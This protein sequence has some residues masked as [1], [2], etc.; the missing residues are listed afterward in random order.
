MPTSLFLLA[1]LAV[2]C[3]VGGAGWAIRRRVQPGRGVAARSTVPRRMFAAPGGEGDIL[4]VAHGNPQDREVLHRLYAIAFAD[5]AF[6]QGA[7]VAGS[8]HAEVVARAVSLLGR[9]ES[10]PRYTPRRPQVLPQLM[11]TV[12]DPDASG[13]AMAAIIGQDPVLAGN[14]LRIASSPLYRAQARPVEDIAHAVAMVGT[15]GIRQLIATALMQPVM[16]TGGAGV[17]GRF[18]DLVW[19]HTLLSAVAAADHAAQEGGDAFAAQLL[20][21][22]QGL[23]SVIVVRIVRDQ[24]AKRPGLVPDAGV[25]AAVLDAWAVPTAQKIAE[26]WELPDRIGQALADQPSGGALDRLGRSLRFGRQAGALAL[27]CSHGRMQDAEA[28]AA[29]TRLDDRSDVTATIWK[30]LRRGG[31][32]M[33]G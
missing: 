6:S 10:L 18:A 5:G 31:D 29:L 7:V 32:D 28:L 24:Y 3:A 22:L 16:G 11:R 2:L 8:G 4:A 27:L 12:N 25:V 1:G 15:D 23:G 9:I 14:L 20:G 26:K 30:R 13:Q 17:F 21:L 33:A 19:E